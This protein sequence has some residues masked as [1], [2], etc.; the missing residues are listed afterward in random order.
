MT[1]KIDAPPARGGHRPGRRAALGPRSPKVYIAVSTLSKQIA[2]LEEKLHTKLFVRNSKGVQLTE[3]G[4]AYVEHVR[5][6][7][8]TVNALTV[9]MDLDLRAAKTD[10]SVLKEKTAPLI[11][12]WAARHPQAKQIH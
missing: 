9:K 8:Q 6:S 2:Q 11:A 3:A 12:D 5:T 4:K 1:I 10:I 7:L